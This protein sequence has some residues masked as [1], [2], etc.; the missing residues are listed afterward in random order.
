M[1]CWLMKSEPS[2]FSL[3]N[4][5]ESPNGTAE[6]EGVRN[7]QA[8]NFMR[9]DMRK[10][11]RVLFHH[12]ATKIP[13]IVGTAVVAREAYPDDTAWDPASKYFDPK[14]DP[15]NPRWVMVDIRFGQAF[16]G[17]L[18][19]RDLRGNPLLKDMMLLRRGM[20][21]SIQPVTQAEYEAVLQMAGGG[22]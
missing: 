7:Y 5:R 20:R 13:A 9:D 19:L 3:R 14:C 12:S 21:L 11:D 17:P 4:L 6:W 1:K 15:Q 10:G 8:R 2:V 18:S 22:D 16:E